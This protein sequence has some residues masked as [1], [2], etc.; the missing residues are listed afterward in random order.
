MRSVYF[1]THPEVVVDADVP[2]PEWSLSERG[3]ERM[4]LMLNQPWVSGIT[5]IYSSTE[6][7][8]V[9]GATVIAENLTF[10]IKQIEALG[11]NDRSATGYLPSDEFEAIADQ[12][13]AFPD[14]S[15]R[16]WETAQAA[17]NRIVAAVTQLTQ[18]DKSQGDIAIVSHGA[19]GALLM[20]HLAGYA[21]SRKYD[22]PGG[23][24]GN[25]YSF[26]LVSQQLN[27]E[28]KAIDG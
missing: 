3:L 10:P 14:E 23:G 6:K 9:D 24:G 17:Q 20:C 1:I 19:V 25:Y 26:D 18:E 4:G 22:Q 7:K 12:F 8:A 28:W 15:V 16:G 21:I 2:V 11:E 5:S 13:F 27:H